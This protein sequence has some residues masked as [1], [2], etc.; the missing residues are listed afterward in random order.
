MKN[1]VLE[2]NLNETESAFLPRLPKWAVYVLAFFLPVLAMTI[3]YAFFGVY[4]FGDKTVLVMDLNVQ[5]VNFFEYY[6][7][8]LSGDAGL[9]YS[10]NKEMG[11]TMFGI[12]AYY[13]S[14]PF[15]LLVAFFPSHM[16]PDAV[17]LITLLKIGASG[18]TFAIFIRHLF[19]KT[20]LS[21]VLFSCAY[22]LM[23]YQMHYQMCIMWLDGVIWL[24][25]ILLGTEQ[26][27]H[28]KS[29]T[30][31]LVTFTISLFSNYYTAYMN[32]LFTVLYFFSRYFI[33]FDEID[34]KDLFKKTLKMLILGLLS[35]LMGAVI[36]I[37]SYLEMFNGKLNYEP[38]NPDIFISSGITSIA[39]RLFIGQYDKITN[40]GTPNI[41]C[42]MLCGILTSVY[43]FNSEIKLRKKLITAGVFAVLLISMFFKD[44]DM[45]WHIFSYPNWFP[46]RYAYVF[47]LLSIVTA[48]EGFYEL[49]KSSNEMFLCGLGGY[50]ILVLISLLLGNKLITNS[51]LAVWSLVFAAVYICGLVLWRKSKKI[52]KNI[53]CA[54]L[55]ILTCVELIINGYVTLN[56]LDRAFR[57]V[58]RENYK[59]QVTKISETVDYMKSLDDGLIRMDKT[60]TRTE[61][62]PLFFGFNGI[63]HYSSNFNSNIVKLNN[64][65]GMLQESVVTRYAGSTVLTD[66]IFGIKYIASEDVIN[67]DYEVLEKIGDTYVYKNPHALSLGFAAD[68]YV[69][70]KPSYGSSYF[71]NQDM[72]ATSVFGDSYLTQNE[73]LDI[74]DKNAVEFTTEYSGSYYLS[75]G[76]KYAGNVELS[77]NGEKTTYPYDNITKKVFYLG[78]HP[79]GTNI[80]VK[81]VN[82]KEIFKPEFA[83]IDI[84][85]FYAACDKKNNESAFNISEYTD[86]TI[87]GTVKIGDGEILF[88]TIPYEKG[89]TA[90][91]DGKECRITSAQNAFMAVFVPEGEHE[92]ELRYDLPGFKVSLVISILTFAAVIILAF[93]KKKKPQ[94]FKLQ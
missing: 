83:C 48:A 87:K 9:I 14:S 5:Y 58:L 23:M 80:S 76:K 66:S 30:L 2:R 16:L 44:V 18:L 79:E 68:D 72:L 84:E 15:S 1:T 34:K 77:I 38:F 63:S 31:F 22:A 56:G 67:E 90:Y 25:L 51:K 86:T 65:L 88:T 74:K 19:E 29:G 40:I 57:Y 85:S 62:D 21:V 53:I 52:T 24:P 64:K 59:N 46:Y 92:V 71:E 12:F 7:K 93:I 55:I 4:P 10:F 73:T 82:T 78:K 35:V 89:W 20:D 42:G 39:R 50:L 37:P 91:V 70:N 54:C 41:F 45:I 69:L 27:I 43:F 26:I 13:L 32:A 49:K 61:N 3:I 94:L 6:R 17:T 28:G 81:F 36:L 11:G 47:C 75:L 33:V 60:V 8:V